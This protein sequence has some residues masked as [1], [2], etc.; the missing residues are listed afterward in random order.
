MSLWEGLR[1]LVYG[2]KICSPPLAVIT[3]EEIACVI[4]DIHEEH[5]EIEMFS[6]RHL[7]DGTSI[8][9]WVV[10]LDGNAMRQ[11]LTI[12]GSDVHTAP[13]EFTGSEAMA[14]F[15]LFFVSNATF[16]R[17]CGVVEV[18]HKHVPKAA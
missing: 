10:I 17:E 5:A 13:Q 16:C 7:A 14:L 9:K 1:S 6:A 2:Y 4:D 11:R 3:P 15:L 8:S 18:Y 12:D